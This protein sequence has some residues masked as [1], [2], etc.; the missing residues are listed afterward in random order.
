M[1]AI[2]DIRVRPA[3]NIEAEEITSLLFGREAAGASLPS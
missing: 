3:E 2:S 1:K